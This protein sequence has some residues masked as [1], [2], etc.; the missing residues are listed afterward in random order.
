MVIVDIRGGGLGVMCE[1]QCCLHVCVCVC[2]CKRERE[3]M[4]ECVCV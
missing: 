2:V 1:S 4:R 3:R